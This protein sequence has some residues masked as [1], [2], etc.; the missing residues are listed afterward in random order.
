MFAWLGQF[1]SRTWMAWL[2]AWL[3][4]WAG[5]RLVA[6]RWSDVARDGQFNFLPRDV[7]SRRGEELLRNAFPSQHPGSS[8]VIVLAHEGNRQ[9]LS[10]EDRLF[11]S[12]KLKPGLDRIAREEQSY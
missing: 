5:T 10:Q 7:P 6:P 12:E 4:L 2:A 3:L 11:I 9:E 1:I 8:L